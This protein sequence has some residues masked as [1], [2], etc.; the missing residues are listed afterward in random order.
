MAIIPVTFFKV[1]CNGCRADAHEGGDYAAW[2]EADQAREEAQASEWDTQVG[3][4][5]LDFCDEC[6]P[7]GQGL[8]DEQD[9]CDDHQLQPTL[10][11][12]VFKCDL[13]GVLYG[14]LA[15]RLEAQGAIS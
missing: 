9:E 15:A 5:D 10:W 11:P 14:P 4:S 13:C 7:F 3:G 8:T 2:A 6:T 12:S 1:E